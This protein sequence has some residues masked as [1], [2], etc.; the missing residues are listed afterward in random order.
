MQR[1]R[2]NQRASGVS[3]LR[4]RASQSGRRPPRPRYGFTLVELLVVI[5]IIA[6]LASL[7]IVAAAGAIRSG[8]EAV[9][10]TLMTQIDAALEEYK[11]NVGSYPPNCQTDET[12]SFPDD[13]GP[14]QVLDER[15]T[16]STLKRHF[17]KAFPSHRETDALIAAFAGLNPDGTVPSDAGSPAESRVDRVLAGGMT[18]AEA[19]VFWI[20]GFSGDPN[21]PISGPGGPSFVPDDGPDPIESRSWSL[22]I[23]A[24]E[25]G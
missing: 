7:L 4:D 14:S 20:S 21:Y 13:N 3:S 17:K 16:L 12:G 1:N 25:L 8:R 9:I 15:K 5:A 10:F 6:I 2:T 22:A 24:T 11:N 18:A 23:E 19:L